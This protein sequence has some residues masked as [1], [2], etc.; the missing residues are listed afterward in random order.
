MNGIYLHIPFC[1]QKCIYCDF[2][3]EIKGSETIRN[4]V[5]ALCSELQ[6]RKNYLPSNKIVRMLYEQDRHQYSPV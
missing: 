6:W 5:D 3:S 1:K 2:F 4:Y